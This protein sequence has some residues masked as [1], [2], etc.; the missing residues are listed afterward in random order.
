MGILQWASHFKNVRCLL[1]FEPETLPEKE[2]LSWIVKKHR[3]RQVGVVPALANLEERLS[4]QPFVT[5]FPPHAALDGLIE[6]LQ[7]TYPPWFA[8]SLILSFCY[9]PPSALFGQGA[10]FPSFPIL[11]LEPATKGQGP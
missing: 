2:V 5:L 7:R 11:P 3:Y 6:V 1:L 9:A 10:R 8:Q 4:Q